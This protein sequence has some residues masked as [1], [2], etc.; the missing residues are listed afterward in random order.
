MRALIECGDVLAGSAE[1]IPLADESVDCVFVGEAF[2]WFDASRAM[3]E[4]ARVLNG[5]GGLVIVHTHWWE[6]EPPLTTEV[7][8]I[9]R[10]PYERF[11][12]QRPP[13]WEAALADSPFEP[14]SQQT[15]DEELV[16]DR[17]ALWAMYSTTSSLAALPGEEREGLLDSVRPL[18]TGPYRLPVK[19]E[20]NWTQLRPV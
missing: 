16:L 17:D 2:H 13:P 10:E 12:A 18:L 20:L 14:L 4:I 5:R 15:F 7:V 6:T 1:A 8:D 3:G 9:L 19:H 11:A